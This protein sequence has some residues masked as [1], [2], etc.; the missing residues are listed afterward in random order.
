MIEATLTGLP[1]VVANVGDIPDLVE[2]GVSGFL[3]EPGDL[4]GLQRALLRILDDEAPHG[5]MSKA[6]R[7]HAERFTV[8][9]RSADWHRLL[10]NRR[11]L[12]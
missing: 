3:F 9:A 4:A 2:S 12:S 10:A 5:M 1:A 6:A 8:D 11:T 7:R